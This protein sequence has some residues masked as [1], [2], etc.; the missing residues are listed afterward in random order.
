MG[1][2]LVEE[3]QKLKR[4]KNAIILAHYY[5]P[6]EIQDIADAVGDSYYLSEVA[7]DSKE[8]IVILCGVKFM[9]ESA[10]I[11]S[12]EKTILMPVLDAG[13]AMADMASE[14]GILELK[15]KY[16]DAYTV[17]YINSTATVKSH[18]DVAVTSSSALDILKN[19]SNKQILF[20]PDK[21]LGGY[22]S[23][24]FPEK[25][26]ILWDG[27]C[28]YHNNIKKED[29]L[30]LKKENKDAKV[31]V[32]PE[33]TKEVRELGDYVGSTTGIIEYATKSDTKDFIIATEEGVL[34][35]LRKRNPN[36]NFFIPGGKISC[37][38]MKKTTLQNLYDTLLNMKNEVVVD[39][40]VAEK[41]LNCLE[42]MHY[43]AK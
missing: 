41:A 34:H 1:R 13:C 24:F 36:K 22:I 31:L 5:Q 25:E 23:E 14:E 10:K 16:P 38:D 43:L 29:I 40:A 6:V 32:H 28:K 7:R 9:A 17:C 2:N 37:I 4:E 33:C 3:I 27:Y 30:N 26:F 42:N 18:C 11:L 8:D 15:H 21:N 39:K 12:P 19:I 20:L 35:E